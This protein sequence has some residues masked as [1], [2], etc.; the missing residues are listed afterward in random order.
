M[1]GTLKGSIDLLVEL[2]S[3]DRPRR[4]RPLPAPGAPRPA[5]AQALEVE[6]PWVVT[7]ASLLCHIGALTLPPALLAQ[8]RAGEPLTA[9]RSTR[10]WPAFRRSARTSSATS[11]AWRASPGH[12]LHEQEL[13]RLRLPRRRQARESDPLGARILKV[14]TDYLDLLDLRPDP[15][16]ALEELRPRASCYD[17]GVLAALALALEAPGETRRRPKSPTR[18]RT[19]RS[20]RA[21]S[22]WRA[23]DP[24]GPAGLPRRHG[25]GRATWSA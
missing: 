21:R 2:L 25:G 23:S 14:A 9:P 6:S 1:E 18:P 12:P 16:A 13:Q 8:V 3:I 17:P 10:P 7:V 24:G 4:L 20:R 5:L 11:R 15:A 22:W 19:R